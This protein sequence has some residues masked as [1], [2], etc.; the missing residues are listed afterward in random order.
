MNVR[1][2]LGVRMIILA[3]KLL[4]HL[5]YLHKLP[6]TDETRQLAHH[7]HMLGNCARH[8]LKLWVVIHKCLQRAGGG[9]YVKS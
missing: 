8:L 6:F 1:Y 5:R 2:L 3:C 9:V 4:L 7:R